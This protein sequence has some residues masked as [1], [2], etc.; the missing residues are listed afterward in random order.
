MKK[1]MIWIIIIL[2]FVATPQF[3]SSTYLIGVLTLVA[4]Y[5]LAALG[6]EMLMGYGGQISLGNGGFIAVGAYVTAILSEKGINPLVILVAVVLI[7]IAVAVVIGLPI[8]QL[9]PWALPY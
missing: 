7:T 8:W 2:C 5:G 9:P 6:L 3:L 4:I 1:N